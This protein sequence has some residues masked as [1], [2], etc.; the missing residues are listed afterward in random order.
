MTDVFSPRRWRNKIVIRCDNSLF[1]CRIKLLNSL[2][3]PAN[4]I[5]GNFQNMR[6]CILL[7]LNYY[8]TAL[9]RVQMTRESSTLISCDIRHIKRN[10]SIET[11]PRRMIMGFHKQTWS[12]NISLLCNNCFNRSFYFQSK[13]SICWHANLLPEFHSK[14]LR[15][16]IWFLVTKI[17]VDVFSETQNQ[18]STERANYTK[19]YQTIPNYTYYTALH[20][21]TPNYTYYTV[22]HQTTP[23]YIKLYLLQR[24]TSNYTR[25]H[26]TKPTTLH[27]IK[28]HQTTPNYTYY[29]V[30]HQTT[31]NY[32][33][34]YQ[35]IPSTPCY[36][37]L[38][39]TSPN[40]NFYT[41]YTKLQLLHLLH[42]TTT[43]TPT[44]PSNNFYTYYTTLQLL[45]L[46]HQT[47]PTTPNN[48]FYT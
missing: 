42:Q 20:E 30:L 29:T 39:Q 37:K 26:K 9:S 1:C 23:N 24:I 5:Y 33:K 8:P 13:S 47:T 2:L 35:T 48:N 43:S 15:N 3:L 16:Y 6:L 28:L 31:P 36:I 27:Y 18:K 4:I 19:L 34:L 40:Y 38:H 46:L 44:T 25:L 12:L 14:V 32:A 7:S 45:D 11:A 41:Y 21:T 17:W 10:L 22:L